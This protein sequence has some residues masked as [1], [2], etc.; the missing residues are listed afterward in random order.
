MERALTFAEIE[1]AVKSKLEYKPVDAIILTF[2]P[3]SGDDK[4]VVA[5]YL[6]RWDDYNFHSGEYVDVYNVG[7]SRYGPN[8]TLEQKVSV[9]QFFNGIEGY[10]YPKMFHEIRGAIAAR[11]R[12]AWNYTSGIDF[13]IFSVD[14]ERGLI[15]WSSPIALRF[16][17]LVP[18]VFSNLDEFV[19]TV[20]NLAEA[21][22]GR[23]EPA[24]FDRVIGQMRM[25]KRLGVLGKILGPDLAKHV[26]GI[27]IPK[28]RE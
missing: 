6:K 15:D 26:F 28:P 9:S 17:K 21:K 25:R 7:Y 11:S 27:F 1:A 14:Q 20:F 22:N 13:L 19:R 8:K 5:E 2:A 4:S 24:D 12:G 23:F 10:F 16:E 3:Y 18:S